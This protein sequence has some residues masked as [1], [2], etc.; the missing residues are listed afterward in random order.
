M[1][2]RTSFPL[3]LILLVAISLSQLNQRS[4]LHP[5]TA[6]QLSVRAHSRF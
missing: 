2:I 1:N 5:I 4:Q 6:L 3:Q